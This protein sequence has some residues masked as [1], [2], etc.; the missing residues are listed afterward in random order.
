M[1]LCLYYV[2]GILQVGTLAPLLVHG[3]NYFTAEAVR[4]RERPIRPFCYY[5]LAAAAAASH[6]SSSAAEHHLPFTILQQRPPSPIISSS[7]LMRAET[8][9]PFRQ[10]VQRAETVS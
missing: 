8:F 6:S 5:P 4:I 10:T 1:F 7:Q 3:T 2:L 9:Y